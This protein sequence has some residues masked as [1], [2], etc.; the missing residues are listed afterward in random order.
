MLVQQDKPSNATT[1]LC[2]QSASHHALKEI[3]KRKSLVVGASIER[4]DED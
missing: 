3:A 1:L 2:R 4:G